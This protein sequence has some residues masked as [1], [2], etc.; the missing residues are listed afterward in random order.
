MLNNCEGSC[1]QETS[2]NFAWMVRTS[3]GKSQICNITFWNC[4]LAVLLVAQQ[5]LV[6]RPRELG[7]GLHD[8]PHAPLELAALRLS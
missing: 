8:L 4:Q 6:E 3:G 2:V 7:V 1:L 5:E